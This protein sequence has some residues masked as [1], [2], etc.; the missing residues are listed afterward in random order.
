MAHQEQDRQRFDRKPTTGHVLLQGMPMHGQDLIP[1][2][3]G[4]N[5]LLLLF[6][7]S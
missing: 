5:H 3:R 6:L 1:S 2:F 7:L 4:R